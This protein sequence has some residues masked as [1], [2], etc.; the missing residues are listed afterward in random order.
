MELH[1]SGL[2]YFGVLE[3]EIN[4]ETTAESLCV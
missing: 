4:A 2:Y 3:V 1:V